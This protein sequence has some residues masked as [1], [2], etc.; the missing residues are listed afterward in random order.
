MTT[1]AWSGRFVA[2]DSQVCYG[3]T[4]GMGKV[5]KLRQ[6]GNTVYACIG[7]GALFSPMVEWIEKGAK[8][9]DTPNVEAEF[10]ASVLVFRDG[11]C[12]VYKARLPYPEEL[13][14]P[15]AWGSGA[16]F[17]IG[18]MHAGA[19]AY[20]AVEI[21]CMR[22]VYSGGP[23]QVIDLQA[24][25]EVPRSREDEIGIVCAPDLPSAA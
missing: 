8:L 16:E 12:L 18:A 14:S 19:T 10:D 6:I 11:K 3:S 23:V 21:A 9:E 1:I 13:S 25:R 5:E 17:A 22:D 7:S 15:D 20:A 2:A 4:K 24:L